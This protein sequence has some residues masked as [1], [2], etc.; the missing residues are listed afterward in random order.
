MSSKH[1]VSKRNEIR[2]VAPTGS[3]RRT[4]PAVLLSFEVTAVAA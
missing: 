3:A 4:V 1:G 2:M